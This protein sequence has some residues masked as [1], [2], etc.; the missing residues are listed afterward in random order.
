[1]VRLREWYTWIRLANRDLEGRKSGFV[2][3]K[4]GFATPNPSGFQKICFM[5]SIRDTIIKISA[6]L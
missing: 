6:L 2:T 4:S 3:Y 1:M 5:D